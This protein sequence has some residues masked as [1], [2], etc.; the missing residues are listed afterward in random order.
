MSARFETVQKY[1]NMGMWTEA[2][3][4]NAVSKSWITAE[5]FKIITGKKYSN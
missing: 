1:F 3:V 4:K 5:E 2:Q